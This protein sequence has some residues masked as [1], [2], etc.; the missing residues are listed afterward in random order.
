M[1][2]KAVCSHPDSWLKISLYATA[3][4]SLSAVGS[5][6]HLLERTQAA[7]LG[8]EQSEALGTTA[9]GAQYAAYVAKRTSPFFFAP[10]SGI[11]SACDPHFPM[12]CSHMSFG[13]CVLE[14]VICVLE[15]G[16]RLSATLAHVAYMPCCCTQAAS[17]L[18][19]HAG[20]CQNG[21]MESSCLSKA[22]SVSTSH[23]TNSRLKCIL[24]PRP[25]TTPQ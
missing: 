22:G 3:A 17:S 8:F 13:I 1:S 15:R 23:W 25:G 6:L 24:D 21:P 7:Q 5:G 18:T 10:R 12:P 16:K 9:H 11:S 19:K 2:T 4:K 14:I 20:T